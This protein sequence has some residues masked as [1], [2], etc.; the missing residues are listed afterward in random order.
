MKSETDRK[1]KDSDQIF[2]AG[3]NCNGQLRTFFHA[4]CPGRLAQE[5]AFF[6]SDETSLSQSAEWLSHFT[7]GFSL[8]SLKKLILVRDEI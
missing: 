8:F 3:K 7:L 2:V 6:V 1:E 4:I 5:V